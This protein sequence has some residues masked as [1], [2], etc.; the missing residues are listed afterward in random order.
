MK[1]ESSLD[2]TSGLFSKVHLL[3]E[4]TE[5][6][7][8]NLEE[9]IL[10]LMYLQLRVYKEEEGRTNWV[11]NNPVLSSAFRLPWIG[12]LLENF[13]IDKSKELN[14]ELSEH[15]EA[16]RKCEEWLSPVGKRR[17]RTIQLA[18]NDMVYRT[19]EQSDMPSGVIKLNKDKEFL[20]SWTQR[21][22]GELSKFAAPYED[23]RIQQNGDVR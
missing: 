18:V 10:F 20:D 5:P 19:L 2:D 15:N 21:W 12:R 8:I 1:A 7:G 9:K 23:T 4:F 16:I 13:Y 6:L 17:A 14:Q 22:S 11:L 3:D